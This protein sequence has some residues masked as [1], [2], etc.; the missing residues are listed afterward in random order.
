MPEDGEGRV[1]EEAISQELRERHE[2]TRIASYEFTPFQVEAGPAGDAMAAADAEMLENL[3]SLGYIGNI[4]LEGTGGDGSQRVR[5]VQTSGCFPPATE[6]PRR[7]SIQ[8]R[9]NC[10]AA[11][12][13]P[14]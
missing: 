3:R 4:D 6:D 7:V 10:S 12:A 11:P 5:A 13:S 9:W 14:T 2:P 8:R 1:L